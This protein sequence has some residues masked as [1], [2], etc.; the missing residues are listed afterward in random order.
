MLFTTEALRGPRTAPI[1][2]KISIWRL[3]AYSVT[4]MCLKQSGVCSTMFLC[5]S[6]ISSPA[7][8]PTLMSLVSG[9]PLLMSF[10]IIRRENMKFHSV[11][12]CFFLHLSQNNTVYK[13]KITNYKYLAWSFNMASELDK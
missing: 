5:V 3:N 4:V 9:L 11:D 6:I 7:L 13:Q 10:S 2:A 1:R 8:L 12:P